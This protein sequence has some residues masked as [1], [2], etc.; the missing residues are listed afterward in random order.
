ME[1]PAVM[2][3][4][5]A[6]S[7]LMVTELPALI[8]DWQVGQVDVMVLMETDLSAVICALLP[9]VSELIFMFPFCP[10]GPA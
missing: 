5:V 10:V 9:K 8:L 6:T 4:A 1:L 3:T 7:E 2:L